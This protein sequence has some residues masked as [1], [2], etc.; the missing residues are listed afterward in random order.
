MCACTCARFTCVCASECVY[1][2]RSCVCEHAIK[3]CTQTGKHNQ[4]QCL[5]QSP[6]V[7]LRHVLCAFGGPGSTKAATVLIQQ[8]S[9]FTGQLCTQG[10]AGNSQA[11]AHTQRHRHTL[12]QWL[13]QQPC[14]ADLCPLLLLA[15]LSLS[16]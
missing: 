3:S 9:Q 8:M 14:Q 10:V 6:P 5:G 12:L 16:L 4:P 11:S 7:F 2:R 1:V 15:C 13:R